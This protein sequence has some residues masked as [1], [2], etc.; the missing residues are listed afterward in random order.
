[1]PYRTAGITP[2][3][4]EF[5]KSMSSVRISVE[6][7]FG[8]IIII[9]LLI[10]RISLSAVGKMYI[11][12]GILKNALTC[13]YGNFTSD[14]FDIEPTTLQDYFSWSFKITSTHKW[15]N[16]CKIRNYM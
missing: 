5:N 8:D 12:C 13:L 6:W 2:Q 10:L 4:E 11:E 14:F 7:L 3:M 15:C 9:N 1:M 16:W